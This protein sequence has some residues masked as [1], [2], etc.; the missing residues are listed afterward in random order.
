MD[1]RMNESACAEQTNEI[2][3]QLDSQFDRV[4]SARRSRVN[5][6]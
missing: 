2:I 4:E 3:N 5:L 1:E 6:G